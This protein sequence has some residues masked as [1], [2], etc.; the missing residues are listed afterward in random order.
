V[1]AY[2]S[3]G[4]NLLSAVIGAV[5][6]GGATVWAQA[7]SADNQRRERVKAEAD[8]IRGFVQSIAD[9]L[10]TVWERQS[11]EIGPHLKSRAKD[12]A[13]RPFPVHQSY[14]IVFDTNASLVGRIPDRELREQIITTYVEAKRFVDSLQY[15]ER[16]HNE[17]YQYFSNLTDEE[18][19]HQVHLENVYGKQYSRRQRK[20]AE[21]IYYSEELTE[22]HTGLEAKIT[23]ALAALNAWL[24]Q[25]GS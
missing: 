19:K 13:V 10:K 2:W 7:R 25:N 11:R 16:T 17:Y 5:I 21:L 6:G 22:A 3:A 4:F 23:T 1:N 20:L 14:F 9:E 18:L 8:L 12:Q 15:Y 24:E